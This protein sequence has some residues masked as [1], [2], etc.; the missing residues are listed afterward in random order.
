[1]LKSKTTSS[2]DFHHLGAQLQSYGNGF[3]ICVE[4]LLEIAQFTTSGTCYGCDFSVD[5]SVYIL[6]FFQ[7]GC[8]HLSGLVIQRM[9]I[10]FACRKHINLMRVEIW[11]AQQPINARCMHAHSRRILK[12][13]TGNMN[14]AALLVLAIVSPLA[15]NAC[16]C[17]RGPD[18]TYAYYLCRNEYGK[19]LYSWLIC[20]RFAASALCFLVVR[21]TVLNYTDIQ[22]TVAIDGDPPRV[23]QSYER[24]Y[25]LRLTSV[26]RVRKHRYL[27][28]SLTP[29]LSPIL[30]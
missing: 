15:A 27:R 10:A 24:I 2:I 28:N 25:T 30:F 13:E 20:I 29:F 5:E 16:S 18:D 12:R 11:A 26:F 6:A 4:R 21:A 23:Y 7:K 22:H 14:F 9:T 1:M 17:M 19:H 8:T 3:G